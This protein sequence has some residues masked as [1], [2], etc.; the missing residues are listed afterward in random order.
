MSFFHPATL[1]LSVAGAVVTSSASAPSVQAPDA[2]VLGASRMTVADYDRVLADPEDDE[3]FENFLAKLPT[4]EVTQGGALRRY[5]VY[6]GDLPL[7]R[8]QVRRLMNAQSGERTTSQILAH[9]P[10]LTVLSLNGVDQ[11]LPRPRRAVTY[12]VDRASFDDPSVYAAAV[13]ALAQGGAAW[14]AACPVKCALSF[15]HSTAEDASPIEG[16]TTFI[17]RYVRDASPFIA[18]GFFPNDPVGA[19]YLYVF[20]RFKTTSYD[21]SGVMRHEIGHVLGYRHEQVRG[22]K[23]CAQEDDDWRPVGKYDPGSAM[24]YYCGGGG[25]MLLALSSEDIKQHAALYGRP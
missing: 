4:F 13:M 17:V 14:V 18:V 8:G 5:Y 7:T 22:I 10:E 21:R 20:P 3:A 12:T 15:S 25:T 19:R 24:H 1:A 11:I 9:K 2:A 16:R 23:G 6:Q